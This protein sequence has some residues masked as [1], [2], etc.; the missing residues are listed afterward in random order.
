MNHRICETFS[1]FCKRTLQ[2]SAVLKHLFLFLSDAGSA[3]NITMTLTELSVFVTK[4]ELDLQL[5]T[6]KER[7]EGQFVMQNNATMKNHAK[8]H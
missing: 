3:A 4:Q 2:T 8:L 7:E 5:R 1:V 6:E